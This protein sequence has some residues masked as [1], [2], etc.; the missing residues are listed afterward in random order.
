[1][2]TRSLPTIRRR[3]DLFVV[4]GLPRSRPFWHCLHFLDLGAH[5]MGG[6]SAV[7][8]SQDNT[9]EEGTHEQWV[10]LS[11]SRG[12]WL[13]VLTKTNMG[14]WFDLVLQMRPLWYMYVCIYFEIHRIAQH[15]ARSGGLGAPIWM[16]GCRF[17]L[18]VSIW[19]EDR[20][21][22]K[23]LLGAVNNPSSCGVWTHVLG[24]DKHEPV[25]SS[26][27][28]IRPYR[29]HERNVLTREPPSVFLDLIL[30]TPGPNHNHQDGCLQTCNSLDFCRQPNPHRTQAKHDQGLFRPPAPSPLMKMAIH[31][32]QS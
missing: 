12:R 17:S 4:G 2:A 18:C 11:T 14:G 6:V 29:L 15:L 5:G 31:L 27:R 10:G 30:P 9:N 3:H 25:F 28:D 21:T 13:D 8:F 26:S 23:Y 1:M 32:C 22:I 16:M 7:C 20:H 19:A 24:I